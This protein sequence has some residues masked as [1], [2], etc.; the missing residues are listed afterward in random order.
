MS[1][2]KVMHTVYVVR[3]ALPHICVNAIIKRALG[4]RLVVGQRILAPSARVR[5]LLPQPFVSIQERRRIRLVA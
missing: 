1:C 4:N 3:L 5:L 2:A